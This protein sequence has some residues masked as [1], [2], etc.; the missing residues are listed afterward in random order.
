MPG[1]VSGI[2]S[3]AMVEVYTHGITG[4]ILPRGMIHYPEHG[5]GSRLSLHRYVSPAGTANIFTAVT[6][7]PHAKMVNVDLETSFSE[8][9]V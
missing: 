7:A 9:D 3:C 5:P 4:K 8:I 1:L 2:A 6:C